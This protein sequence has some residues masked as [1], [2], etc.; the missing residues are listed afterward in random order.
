MITSG[1]IMPGYAPVPTRAMGEYFEGEHAPLATAYR[2]GS[3]GA[4][5]RFPGRV[6]GIGQYRQAA[7]GCQGVG[8]VDYMLSPAIATMR[9]ARNQ[10]RGCGALGRGPDGI[11]QMDAGAGARQM[12]AGAGAMGG[13]ILAFMVVGILIA[14]ALSYQAGKAMTPPGSSKKTWGWI[15]VPVGMFTGGTGLGVMG[16]V[17]NAKRK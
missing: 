12:D 15:G 6:R 13:A 10:T 14:G 16:W 2:D 5:R 7:A 17:S 3:L 1:S 8:A 9:A 4:Y 11:G